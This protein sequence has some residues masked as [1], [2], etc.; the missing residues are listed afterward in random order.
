MG[1]TTNNET[2]QERKNKRLPSQEDL[3]P[4]LRF[5]DNELLKALANSTSLQKKIEDFKISW[6]NHGDVIQ[7]LFKSIEE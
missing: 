3:N 2:A 7:K 6:A 1:K 5:V 4:N